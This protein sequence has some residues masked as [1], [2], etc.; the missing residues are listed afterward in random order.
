MATD[1]RGGWAIPIHTK[2]TT[3]K[4][5]YAYRL[6][7]PNAFPRAIRANAGGTITR[8][9]CA[10]HVSHGASQIA[11]PRA[12]ATAETAAVAITFAPG[13]GSGSVTRPST[14]EPAKNMAARRP[15]SLRRSRG[16]SFTEEVS[17]WPVVGEPLRAGSRTLGSGDEDIAVASA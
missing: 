12:S 16:L 11:I 2:T 13:L 3:K 1:V 10:G 5:P 7:P 15:R 8:L 6:D 4:T 14:P 9:A 17:L